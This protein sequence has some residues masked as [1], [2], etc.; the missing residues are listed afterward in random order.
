MNIVDVIKT[1]LSGDMMGKLSQLIGESEQKTKTAVAAAVPA[2][3]AGLSSAASDPAKASSL[4][5][6]LGGLDLGSLGNIG[7]M[8][9]GGGGGLLEKGGGLLSSVL[10]GNVLGGLTSA[11]EKYS[12]LGGG[13]ITKL[14]SALLPMILGSLAAQ[15]GGKLDARGLSDLLAGQ[16]QNIMNSLPAGL[17]LASVPGLGSA[18]AAVSSAAGAAQQAAAGTPSWL[19]PLALL[20]LVAAGAW[21]W[22]S[23]KAP[24]PAPP[25]IPGADVAQVTKDLGGWF[26]S[27]TDSLSSVND[28]ASAEAAL[29]KLT[30]LSGKLD[31]VRALVDKMPAAG[32]SAVTKLVNDQLGRLRELVDRVLAIPGVVDKVKPVTDAIFSKL[33]AMTA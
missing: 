24:A 4:N 31:G 1:Q 7:S 13:V 18:S 21:W 23:N 9:S 15:R 29:P 22:F 19:L 27:L 17:S 12:G 26:T 10:G 20:G 6:A 8:L 5:S 16:K 3:L 2:L 32:K 33:S 11:L 30:E 28:A 25:A 14:L